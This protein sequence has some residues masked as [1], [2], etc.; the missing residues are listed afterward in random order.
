[1]ILGYPLSTIAAQ[2][3]IVGT[4]YDVA[5]LS[6]LSATSVLSDK[7]KYPYFTRL[8]SSAADASLLMKEFI[9]YYEEISVSGGWTDV[10]VISEIT[11]ITSDWATNFINFSEPEINIVAYRQ[12]LS[13]ASDDDILLELNQIKLS[14]SRV[15][16]ASIY[17]EWENF[18]EQADSIGLIGDSY[19]W[20]VPSS[21]VDIPF[22][23]LEKSRGVIGMVDYFPLSN[24]L[25]Q[26]I[27]LWRSEESSKYLEAGPGTTPIPL[28]YRAFDMVVTAAKALQKLD[29]DNLL[30]N[31]PSISAELWTSIIRNITFDGVS[32]FVSFDNNGDRIGSQSINYYSPENGWTLC[33]IWSKATGIEMEKEIIWYSNTTEIPDLDIRKPIK[34]WSCHDKQSDIDETGKT[35][36]IKKPDGSDV[37]YIDYDYY[38][39]HFI[40]CKNL[41]D[42]S[43]DNCSSNYLIL[44]IVF[45]IITGILIFIS[46]LL[47]VFVIVFGY[48]LNFRRLKSASPFFLLIILISMIIGYISIYSWF[49]KPHPVSCGFQPWLL[50]LSINSMIVALCVKNIRIWRIF[51]YPMKLT[52]I[53]NIDLFILWIV[54]LLPGILILILWTSIATPT[55]S[56][57][58]IG[59]HHHYVCSTGG[60]GDPAGYVFFSIFVAYCAV[61]LL[62]GGL[63]SILI[64]NV[65]S[66]FNEAKI[67]SISIYNLGF[68]AV[69][70][71]PVFLVVNPFN[72]FIAWILR[73]CAIL[74]AFTATMFILFV[75]IIVGIFISDKGKNVTQFKSSIKGPMSSSVLHSSASSGNSSG[76][77]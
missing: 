57:R 69:V 10:G 39:D 35:I 34:Y 73:T 33:G 58:E 53:T 4:V 68:L 26:F 38:C 76:R 15:I 72:P 20:I 31:Y 66:K 27:D 74:Y 12:F 47:I 52:R 46:I 3:G 16:V 48:I 13:G 42:E 14:K 6:P 64:R 54:L 28:T 1:M 45:G 62:F 71:I 70:I 63:V 24:E 9:L 40:D 65:P 60:V 19:V 51:K 17:G 41:S 44:F 25:D 8:A 59:D 56:F 55:A 2:A 30:D 75:P 5:Q 61:I 32:G 21:V 50:G 49:G 67:L 29:D 37:N 11:P 18:I 77:D 7:V 22:N 43:S 23:S 36:E